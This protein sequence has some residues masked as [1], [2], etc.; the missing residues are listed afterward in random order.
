[1]FT[2]TLKAVAQRYHILTNLQFAH[3]FRAPRNILKYCPWKGT[4]TGLEALNLCSATLALSFLP[5]LL[6]TTRYGCGLLLPSHKTQIL[7]FCLLT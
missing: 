4:K 2:C 1:M 7:A 5:V 6:K 3:N